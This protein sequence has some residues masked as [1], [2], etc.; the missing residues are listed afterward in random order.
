M[1]Y[2]ICGV[3]KNRLANY[4]KCSWQ[5]LTPFLN[6]TPS[7]SMSA[8]SGSNNAPHMKKLHVAACHLGISLLRALLV[9]QQLP[10]NGPTAARYP[11]ISQA[12]VN[13]ESNVCSTLLALSISAWGVK[14]NDCKHREL[15]RPS[16]CFPSCIIEIS[17][18]EQRRPSSNLWQQPDKVE[19]HLKGYHEP[20]ITFLLLPLVKCRYNKYSATVKLVGR[21]CYFVHGAAPMAYLKKCS[22]DKLGPN[23]QHSCPSAKA[24]LTKVKLFGGLAMYLT[25]NLQTVSPW[26]PTG[27]PQ[28]SCSLWVWQTSSERGFYLIQAES[29]GTAL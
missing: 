3:W 15:L 14:H 13:Y 25:M 26:L 28:V 19:I 2:A 10:L 23:I 6:Q 22:N 11:R 1:K 16:V 20:Q 21:K 18:A 12:A 29:K 5:G 4:S 24:R 9:W 17:L 27:W 8:P 7:V